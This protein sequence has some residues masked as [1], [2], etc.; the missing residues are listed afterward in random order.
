M[1][2]R[3]GAIYID[4][5]LNIM[6]QQ[7][8]RTPGISA[9]RVGCGIIAEPEDGRSSYEIDRDRILF[10]DAFRALAD[11]TQVH[12]TTGN[13]YVRSRLTHSLEVSCVGRTLGVRAAPFLRD[14]GLGAFQNSDIG[15]IV[16]A[17]CLMHDIG[18]PP[19]GHTGERIIS[20]FF[21]KDS[22]GRTLIEET[23]PRFQM[24]MTHFEGNAQG[25]RVVTRLQGWR[26]QG[27]LGLTAATLA[28]FGKYPFSANP[29]DGL[30]AKKHKY[31]F[32]QD[33]AR[34]FVEVAEATGM[35]KNGRELA[36]KRHPLAYLLEAADDICYQVVDLED[37]C[38]LGVIRFEEAEELLAGIAQPETLNYRSLDTKRQKLVYLRGRA[39]DRLIDAVIET[40]RGESTSLFNGSHPGDILFRTR[41][42]E[43]MKVIARF[44]KTYIYANANRKEQDNDAEVMLGRILKSTAEALLLRERAGGPVRHPALESFRNIELIPYEREGWLRALCDHV[45]AMTDHGAIV[46]AERLGSC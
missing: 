19:F 46:E 2:K 14:A 41:F 44:S 27:G 10:S 37:A 16:A 11:K 40:A 18:N 17:A 38:D 1:R 43:Q 21:L 7:I 8:L 23:S 26:G 24:E 31:G 5:R 3:Q 30:D 15:H 13:D 9:Q 32:Y 6:D 39:I 25:F 42:G 35:V 33:D 22:F 12:G 45:G 36:W 34:A 20:E 28:A 4:G 29:E